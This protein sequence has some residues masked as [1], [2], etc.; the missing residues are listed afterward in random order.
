MVSAEL[1]LIERPGIWL[2]F[3]FRPDLQPRLDRI[4]RLALED[5]P[6]IEDARYVRELLELAVRDDLLGPAGGPN[7]YVVDMS[8][9]GRSLVGKLAPRRPGPPPRPQGP[10]G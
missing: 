9:R 10:P 7:E 1:P 8:V 4:A 6:I 5:I 3:H 2:G